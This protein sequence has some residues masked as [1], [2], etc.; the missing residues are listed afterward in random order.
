M[1]TLL[2]DEEAAQS[3]LNLAKYQEDLNEMTI[4]QS[5][6]DRQGGGGH[7]ELYLHG[8]RCHPDAGLTAVYDTRGVLVLLCKECSA[9]GLIVTVAKKE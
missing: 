4:E 5:G 7:G 6:H 2:T 8:S 1:D 3:A 9:W